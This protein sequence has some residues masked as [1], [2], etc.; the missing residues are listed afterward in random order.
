MSNWI[1]FVGTDCRTGEM[2]V[3]GDSNY[4]S[5]SNGQCLLHV[6]SRLQQ[7]QQLL[8]PQQQQMVSNGTTAALM[9]K[10]LAVR[11][12]DD[13]VKRTRSMNV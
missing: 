12:G 4:A 1:L 5:S 8:S 9:K 7:Q 3:S 11:P 6:R 10:T 13:V 2:V